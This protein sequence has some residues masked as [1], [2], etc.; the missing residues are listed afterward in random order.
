MTAA[1][2][3]A[4]FG[5]SAG[6]SGGLPAA[7]MRADIDLRYG[8]GVDAA[9][10][11]QA[12][13]DL[14]PRIDFAASDR[15][16]VRLSARLRLDGANLLDPGEAVTETYSPLSKPL[17]L[18]NAGLIELRDAYLER[19]LA[20][21]LVRIGK[22]QIVWG[23]LDGIKILDVLNPQDFREFI[24]DDFD[25]S[26]IGLWS[27]YVD[28]AGRNWRSEFVAVADNSGHAIPRRGA[29]FELTA[30]RFR[31]GA[32]PGTPGLDTV[33]R[34]RS[35]G[36]DTGALGI[37]LSRRIGPLDVAALGYSGI[38]FEPL[39]RIVERA[40][41]P[42]VDR[43]VER[44]VERYYE[45]RELVGL[46]AEGAAGRVAFRGEVAYQPG[47]R[48][49]VRS[50][51]LLEAIGRDQLTAGIGIDVDGPFD[52]FA[53]L[54]FVHDEVL[55]APASL[56]RPSRDR[57]AT[58]TLRR[59]FRYETLTAT[60]R[61]YYARDPGD[62][63]VSLALEYRPGDNARLRLAADGFGGEPQGLFGQFRDRDRVTL[64]WLY[65]F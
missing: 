62:S 57:I 10:T 6:L 41:A 61:W 33:T 4:L 56:V 26:R 13:I 25:N 39:G 32:E 48:F 15:W 22:Q 27:A 34:K 59:S 2:V 5:V 64:Q 20:G 45:R 12:S 42:I 36:V 19:R 14:E 52:V 30:P 35:V 54:Q 40:D 1:R 24:L 28:L 49:N 53:N 7:E 55:D 3:I 9:E 16:R 58:L 46:S 8:H 23:R 50:G 51:S 65:T 43:Y 21:G 44:Y 47:R 63:M 18:G 17:A 31:Y 29:W 38:D 37:R 60:L 11:V